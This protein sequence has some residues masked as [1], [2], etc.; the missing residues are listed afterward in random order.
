MELGVQRNFNLN[1]IYAPILGVAIS[2]ISLQNKKKDFL[3]KR[4]KMILEEGLHIGDKLSYDKLKQLYEV[5]GISLDIEEKDFALYFLD[6]DNYAGIQSGKNKET[7]ILTREYIS[8]EYM[9]SIKEKLIANYNL[10]PLDTINYEMLLQMYNS[11]VRKISLKSFCEDILEISWHTV[12]KMKVNKSMPIKI[13]SGKNI[14]SEKIEQVK[15]FIINEAK[16]HIGDQITLTEFLDLYNECGN[17]LTQKDFAIYVLG[18]SPNSYN[19]LKGNKTKTIGVFSTYVINPDDIYKLREKV[20]LEEKLHIEEMISKERFLE[21]Y[22]KYSG[23]M[24]ENMFA[25]E[26]L[27][28]S[29]AALKYMNSDGKALILKNIQISDEYVNSVR[30]IIIK[31]NKIPESQINIEEFQRLF[32]KY[33]YILN[34]S[35]FASLILDAPITSYNNLKNKNSKKANSMLY[36]LMVYGFNNDIRFNKDGI[37][38]LPVGKTDF[39]KNNIKKIIEYNYIAKT[40]NIVFLCTEFN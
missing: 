22:K 6:I 39:N 9:E 14:D 24:P 38:N 23:I 10:K 2:L 28:I 18:A 8:K 30:E 16:I 31:E 29:P 32:Q 13:F 35:Q 11:D 37:F 15:E 26:I 25:E 36:T 21:L 33:G 19:R 34:E 4:E 7:E 40:K 5:Y 17:G 27:D 1:E 3:D 20:I 12:D